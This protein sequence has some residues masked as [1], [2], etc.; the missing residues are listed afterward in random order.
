MIELP[1]DIKARRDA[2][3]AAAE[4]GQERAALAKKVTGNSK[5]IRELLPGALEA[6]VT[7]E[8]LAKLTKVSRQTLHAWRDEEK[9]A[10]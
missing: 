7:M 4:L 5:K 8:S 9:D 2:E 6:G 3:D 10:N 1:D